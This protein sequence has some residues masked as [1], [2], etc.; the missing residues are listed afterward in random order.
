MCVCSYMRAC[1]PCFCFSLTTSKN[2]NLWFQFFWNLYVHILFFLSFNSI[3]FDLSMA[4]ACVKIYKCN[5]KETKYASKAG[6]FYSSFSPVTRSRSHEVLREQQNRLRLEQEIVD[7]Q[8]L[9]EPF[10]NEINKYLIKHLLK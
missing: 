4:F 6:H 2:S 3:M 10:K 1:F 7:S 5:K 9:R 8:I